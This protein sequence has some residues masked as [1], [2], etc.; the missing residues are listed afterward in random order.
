M[1]HHNFRAFTAY[2]LFIIMAAVLSGCLFEEA[3]EPVQQIEALNFQTDKEYI[4]RWIFSED[5]GD[6]FQVVDVAR[7]A[8]QVVDTNATF[9]G[10]DNLIVLKSTAIDSRDSNFAKTWYRRNDS[11]FTAI[12]FSRSGA[13]PNIL[14]KARDRNRGPDPSYLMFPRSLKVALTEGQNLNVVRPP[15]AMQQADTTMRIEPRV[16]YQFPFLENMNWISF[17]N[18]FLQTR[19]IEE[20]LFTTVDAGTFGTFMVA[21][22]SDFFRDSFR[23]HDFVA[24]NGLVKREISFTIRYFD[25]DNNPLP[26]KKITE[27]VELVEINPL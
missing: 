8:M 9:N 17:Q 14:P 1:I 26:R 27:K 5:S 16:V 19:N 6:G 4:Y 20:R 21:T 11:E 13:N 3:D 10:E 12:A 22:N 7:F 18:P 24:E 15:F 2:A 23:W 25:E